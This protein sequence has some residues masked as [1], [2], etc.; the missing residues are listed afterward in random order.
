M[1]IVFIERSKLSVAALQQLITM[2]VNII[3]V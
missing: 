3:D 1:K 2:Q